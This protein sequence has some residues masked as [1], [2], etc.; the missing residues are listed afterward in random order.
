MPGQVE[1]LAADLGT[2]VPR[3]SRRRRVTEIE[4]PGSVC[5]ITYSAYVIAPTG[6]FM[7][8][9][10][11][12]PESRNVVDAAMVC[13]MASWLVSGRP[14]HRDVAEQPV[15]GLVHLGGARREAADGDL[16]PVSTAKGG[17]LGLPRGFGSRRPRSSG[18]SA[19]AT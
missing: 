11:R 10:G 2:K 5:L 12:V 8:G 9:Y 18:S 4:W 13:M 1:S 3:V 7:P 17:Q 16:Q 19:A 14:V 15:L 6:G